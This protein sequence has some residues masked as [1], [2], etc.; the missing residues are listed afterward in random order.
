L[1]ILTF[2][3]LKL[4]LALNLV[5]YVAYIPKKTCDSLR[6]NGSAYRQ[7]LSCKYECYARILFVT[8]ELLGLGNKT[9]LTLTHKEIKTFPK[10]KGD[11]C[12]QIF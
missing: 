9:L 3:I 1:G 2:L 4:R 5:F 10:K 8:F 6:I 12:C 7:K 11:F